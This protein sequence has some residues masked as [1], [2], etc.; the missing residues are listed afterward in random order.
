[1]VEGTGVVGIPACAQRG[2]EEREK[3]QEKDN[4]ETRRAQSFRGEEGET[5]RGWKSIFTAYF[6]ASRDD[7]SSYFLCSND[8]N[9]MHIEC[10]LIRGMEMSGKLVGK[11]GFVTVQWSR[12]VDF[13]VG[14]Y[15]G[16]S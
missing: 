1:M 7:L 16:R 15:E 12:Q 14:K 4:A 5:G 3:E 6:T 10:K 2:S 9:D 13:L 11:N 8:S